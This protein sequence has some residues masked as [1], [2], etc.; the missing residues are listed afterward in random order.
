MRCPTCGREMPEVERAYISPQTGVVSR[1]GN[2]AKL[3][4]GQEKLFRL[5]LDREP[6]VVSHEMLYEVTGVRIPKDLAVHIYQLRQ[7]LADLGIG[8]KNEH[9]RGYRL[10]FFG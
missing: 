5:L 10:V 9:G 4:R 6:N 2:S 7:R 8:V 1:W 3:S